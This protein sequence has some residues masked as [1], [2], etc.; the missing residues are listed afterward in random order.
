MGLEK[1]AGRGFSQNFIAGLF[2]PAMRT[3]ILPLAV[4]EIFSA[5]Q[6]GCAKA[7]SISQ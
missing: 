1:K 6:I 4:R 5:T 3:K 2:Y 7:L